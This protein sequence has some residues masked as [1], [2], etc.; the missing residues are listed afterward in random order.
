LLFIPQVKKTPLG[1]VT[2]EEFNVASAR[3]CDFV[4]LAVDGD[5]AKEYA[6]QITQVQ[7]T[8]YFAGSFTLILL[9]ICC[10]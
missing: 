5:F 8:S 7:R 4:F 1:D 6:P 3:G 9:C 2:I 10:L